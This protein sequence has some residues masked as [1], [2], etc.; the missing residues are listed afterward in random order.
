MVPKSF[1]AYI[2]DLLVA[3]CLWLLATGMLVGGCLLLQAHAS[4]DAGSSSPKRIIRVGG[5]NDFAPYEFVDTDGRPEGY[6]VELMQAVA[7]QVGREADIILG[8]W[9]EMLRR[10]E[11]KEIDALTGLL[12]SK[13]R[14]EKF[15]FFSS[16]RHDFLCRLCA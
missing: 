14:D 10:L 2:T 15:C 7:H 4:E 9:Q 12:Y 16:L 11:N 6:T 5:S 13:E 1:F 3:S 8:P